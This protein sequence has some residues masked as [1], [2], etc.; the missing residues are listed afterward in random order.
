MKIVD[1]IALVIGL[2]VA[3]APALPAADR[4]VPPEVPSNIEAPAGYKPFLIAHAVGTQNYICAPSPTGPKW[5]FIG[6]QATLYDAD[7]EQ[8]LTHFQSTNP[9]QADAIQATWEHSRDSSRVWGRR[10]F[11]ST[12]INY[13]SPDAIEWLLLEVTGGVAGPTGGDKM[14]AADYIQRVNTVGGKEPLLACT[15]AIL[16]QR[17]LVPYEADYVFYRQ[18]NSH[19]GHR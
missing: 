6:P 9:L 11:G 1:V 16:N 17:Q 19:G 13:V 14:L 10:Q 3:A 4:I 12:D 8:K 2:E 7:G 15:A 18:G 5:L